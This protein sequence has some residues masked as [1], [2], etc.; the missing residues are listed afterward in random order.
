MFS[1]SFQICHVH[2]LFVVIRLTSS[3]SSPTTL[4]GRMSSASFCSMNVRQS[5]I[6]WRSP[7]AKFGPRRWSGV[8]LERLDCQK[9]PSQHTCIP[10]IS[11][12]W[13]SFLVCFPP[14]FFCRSV[15]VLADDLVSFRPWFRFFAN[16]FLALF[17]VRKTSSATSDSKSGSNSAFSSLVARTVASVWLSSG[18]ASIRE[19][20]FLVSSDFLRNSASRSSCV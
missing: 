6:P 9:Y 3:L 20:L 18:V 2:H 1:D 5:S 16:T 10:D 15:R 14:P 12:D 11:D 8:L 4:S 13:A 17:G 19:A 7:L